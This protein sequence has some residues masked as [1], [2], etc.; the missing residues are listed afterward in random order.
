MT[1]HPRFRETARRLW[2]P[3]LGGALGYLWHYWQHCSG[4]T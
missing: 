2:G 4:A 3:A 1:L